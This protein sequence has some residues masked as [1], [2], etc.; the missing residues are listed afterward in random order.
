MD[1]PLI[2]QLYSEK[3]CEII[4]DLFTNDE[5]TRGSIRE[6][7]G[8]KIILNSKNIF[9]TGS[10]DAIF[11][12]CCTSKFASDDECNKVA[13]II[14]SNIN[15]QDP[16]PYISEQQGVI[17]AERI[18]ISLCFFYKRIQH[19]C[20]YKGYPSPDF[21]RSVGKSLFKQNNCEEISEHFQQWE[22]FLCERFI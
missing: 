13:L 20:K 8:N 1:K 15:L 17:L 9:V 11:L 4:R 3:E 2:E 7:I 12:V 10:L 16:M 5:S 14:H 19:R 21:Y 18:F 6:A 22:N